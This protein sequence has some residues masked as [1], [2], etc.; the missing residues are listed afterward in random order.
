MDI[1]KFENILENGSGDRPAACSC[2]KKKK[3]RRRLT[4]MN[5]WSGDMMAEHCGYCSKCGG[6]KPKKKKK[7]TSFLHESLKNI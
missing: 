4:K 1:L 5:K 2:G 6:M 7:K 3:V